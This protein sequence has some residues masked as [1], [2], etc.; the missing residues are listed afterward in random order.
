M[1]KVLFVG[2][3]LLAAIIGFA[4]AV[5]YDHYIGIRNWNETWAEYGS[6][7]FEACEN[8]EIT[9]A[10]YPEYSRRSRVQHEVIR[11]DASESC[12]YNMY[13]GEY[14]GGKRVTFVESVYM[15]LEE[16]PAIT[17]DHGVTVRF[18]GEITLDMGISYDVVLVY[19]RAKDIS[20]Q[21]YSLTALHTESY[22]GQSTLNEKSQDGMLSLDYTTDQEYGGQSFI[23]CVFRSP[24]VYD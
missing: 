5:A 20:I 19:D 4:G 6:Q 3:F 7:Q 16:L 17:E 11:W 23:S 22:E 8:C 15:G 13:V 9:L 10:Y 21:S 2:L 24:N 14:Q 18:D 12:P 1:K